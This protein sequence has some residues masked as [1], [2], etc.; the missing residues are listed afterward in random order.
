MLAQ[1]PV[2]NLAMVWVVMGHEM[3]RAARKDANHDEIVSALLQVGADVVDLSQHGDGLLDLLVGFRGVL[4]LIEIK[5]GAKPA[6]ARRLTEPQQGFLLRMHRY[7]CYVVKSIDEA[8]E[9]I[10]K[11][12]SIYDRTRAVQTA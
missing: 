9:A 6:S 11:G 1:Q 2:P 3:R 5:D 10:K 12:A 7:P 8:L 4:M